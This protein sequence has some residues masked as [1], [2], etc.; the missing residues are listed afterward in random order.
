M[1]LYRVLKKFPDPARAILN[2]IGEELLV[3]CPHL[4]PSSI[5]ANDGHKIKVDFNPETPG[6]RFRYKRCYTLDVTISG[7]N[8]VCSVDHQTGLWNGGGSW[9]GELLDPVA[10]QNAV[11]FC[12]DSIA[13][14]LEVLAQYPLKKGRGKKR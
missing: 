14:H 3:V 9:S 7:D 13:N 10:F 5:V 8:I 1:T 12:K 6:V 11:Q 4:R 2:E